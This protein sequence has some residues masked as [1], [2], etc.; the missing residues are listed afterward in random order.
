MPT[1]CALGVINLNEDSGESRNNRKTFPDNDD[2]I[3]LAHFCAACKPGYRPTPI[4]V[5][6][7]H[8]VVAC[9]KIDNCNGLNWFNGCSECSTGFAY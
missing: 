8:V 6:F 7:K 4:N 2:D 1:N 5:L 3:E 9:D